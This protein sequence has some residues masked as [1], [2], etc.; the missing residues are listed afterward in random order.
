MSSGWSDSAT[1]PY[2][3]IRMD[4]LE[5]QRFQRSSGPDGR[6]PWWL[7]LAREDGARFTLVVADAGEPE[8]GDFNA[9]DPAS[10]A[11]AER[12]LA[13]RERLCAEAVRFIDSR[14]VMRTAAADEVPAV[15]TVFCDAGT[16]TVILELRWE[17]EVYCAWHVEFTSDHNQALWPVAF[18]SRAL[19]SSTPPWRAPYLDA[20]RHGSGS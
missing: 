7:E 10:L 18:G 17:S 4:D 15:S 5:H 13:E 19:G 12:V 8:I 20:Q 3:C 16:R 11:L 14:V 1:P 2:L 6:P 9:P